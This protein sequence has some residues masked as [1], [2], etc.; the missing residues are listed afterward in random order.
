MEL[1]V[2]EKFE[3]ALALTKENHRVAMEEIDRKSKA[4]EARDKRLD[5]KFEKRHQAAMR[6][7]DEADK[8]FEKR[9]DSVRKL[10]VAGTQI[11]NHLAKESREARADT[12]ALK[13]ELRE[14]KTEMRAF[15]K[16]QGNGHG[17]S[18]NRGRR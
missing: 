5:E 6:R 1:D 3:A 4:S 11:V 12:R 8:R 2:R 9:M 14:F 18:N 16:A 15:I 10:I 17:G 13:A 7:M